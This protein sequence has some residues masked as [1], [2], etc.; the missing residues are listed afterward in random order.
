MRVVGIVAEYN[1]LHKGHQIHIEEAK[2]AAGAGTAVVVMSGDFVQRGEPAIVDKVR[3]TRM[4][5]AA[6]ADAVLELP[7]AAATASAEF[8]ADAAVGILDSLG[9]V[10]DLAYGCE[11]GS[12]EQFGEAARVLLEEPEPFRETLQRELRQGRTYP[13]ARS[14]ALAK[15]L[16]ESESLLKSPNNILAV[17]YHKALLRRGSRICPHAVR[18]RGAG[19]HESTIPGS[20]PASASAVRAELLRMQA[21]AA[22]GTAASHL[23]EDFPDHPLWKQLPDFTVRELDYSMEADDLSDL[24]HLAVSSRTAKEL[25]EFRDFPPELAS[26]IHRKRRE[27]LSF[28]ELAEQTKTREITRSRVNRAL[29]ALILGLKRDPGPIRAVRLLGLRRG[30]PLLR[31]MQDHSRLPLVTKM[32]DA[33]EG[34]FADD[35]RAAE[36]YRTLVW[37][38][39]GIQLA[40]EYRTGPVIG[41]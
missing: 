21:G 37:R 13:A 17:E 11:S 9:V 2:K 4:A 5:L 31:A 38:K 35:I 32:A 36:I 34:V 40:D 16:P 14:L 1:P 3:R 25:S 12:P 27:L 7:V 18:R 41:S 33:P 29:L 22:E 28:S 8:F 26:R 20:G 10:T 23:R 6:G 15:I 39:T 30:S 19:H 24:L